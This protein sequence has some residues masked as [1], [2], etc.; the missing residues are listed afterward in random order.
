MGRWPPHLNSLMKYCWAIPLL[1][2]TGKQPQPS[3][4]GSSP[5]LKNTIGPCFSTGSS[6]G[7]VSEE[8]RAA[9][10]SCPGL[11]PSATTALHHLHQRAATFFFAPAFFFYPQLSGWLNS[12]V[13]VPPEIPIEQGK[14]PIF[15]APPPGLGF[16]DSSSAFPRLQVLL[17]AAI[18][19]HPSAAFVRA[20]EMAPSGLLQERCGEQGALA[21]CSSC[22]RP[23]A[24]KHI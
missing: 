2:N 11:Q 14:T 12:R 15:P 17:K 23:E 16:A 6:L 5:V 1:K 20:H 22:P 19:A 9:C 4:K 3:Q 8:S 7:S 18:F 24:A 10:H 13:P 21:G